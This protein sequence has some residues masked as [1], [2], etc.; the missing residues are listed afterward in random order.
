MKHISWFLSVPQHI[1]DSIQ[2][3]LLLAHLAFYCLFSS[4]KHKIH[5]TSTAI[6]LENLEWRVCGAR[7][8][9]SSL[10]SYLFN[11]LAWKIL[12]LFFLNWSVFH[13]KIRMLILLLLVKTM[14]WKF[15]Y[16]I[17]ITPVSYPNIGTAIIAILYLWMSLHTFSGRFYRVNISFTVQLHQTWQL[18][19]PQLKGHKQNYFSASNC[20]GHSANL[21]LVG[22]FSFSVLISY[23]DWIICSHVSSV[24]YL[25]ISTELTLNRIWRGRVFPHN[26]SRKEEMLKDVWQFKLLIA[27][28]SVYFIGRVEL[29]KSQW[30]YQDKLSKL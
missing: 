27:I 2:T 12:F 6:R 28:L 19:Q 4:I 29:D 1:S 24:L 14:K 16:K 5:V 17:T 26:V 21:L 23:W 9:I 25:H 13:H 8:A 11:M 15:S 7:K 18:W 10:V 3:L 20:T 22:V 30:V